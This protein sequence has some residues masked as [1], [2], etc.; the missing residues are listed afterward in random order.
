LVV[1]ANLSDPFICSLIDDK[2]RPCPQTF[3]GVNLATRFKL[4][5]SFVH[6]NLKP[7]TFDTVDGKGR[8]IAVAQSAP[9]P[10]GSEKSAEGLNVLSPP[11]SLRSS[12]KR[13]QLDSVPEE[14]D[15]S[16][17]AKR[18]RAAEENP[19]E[20]FITLDDVI[21]KI[22]AF[23]KSLNEPTQSVPTESTP[24]PPTPSDPLP[25]ARRTPS[26][27]EQQSPTQSVSPPLF[28]MEALG[29]V[30]KSLPQ[31]QG[32]EERLQA[33]EDNQT[34]LRTALRSTLSQL[35]DRLDA[36]EARPPPPPAQEESEG[37]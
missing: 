34:A 37:V 2:G 1:G 26:P 16:P 17:L 27:P 19:V 13:R 7:G 23:A 35:M 29:A 9:P 25:V 20:S 12:L 36:M 32:L 18:S 14:P 33:L 10:R 30:V 15:E 5:V 21:A 24:P 11:T 8:F 28:D 3:S 31:I 6:K 4:H 22:E